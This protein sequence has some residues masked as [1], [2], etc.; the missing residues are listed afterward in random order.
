MAVGEGA[1]HHAEAE[2]GGRLMYVAIWLD[3]QPPTADERIVVCTPLL[4]RQ[5]AAVAILRSRRLAD[6]KSLILSAERSDLIAFL[7]ELDQ[8]DDSWNALTDDELVDAIVRKAATMA[9]SEVDFGELAAVAFYVTAVRKIPKPGSYP[10]FITKEAKPLWDDL[11]VRYRKSLDKF[12]SDKKMMWAAAVIMLKRLAAEKRV[13]PFTKDPTEDKVRKMARNEISRRANNGNFK[14]LKEVKEAFKF[15]KR[16]GLASALAPE[17]FLETVKHGDR[18]YVTTFQ[19]AA[20]PKGVKPSFAINQL[21]FGRRYGGKPE[22]FAHKN[23]DNLTDVLVEPKGKNLHF[24]LT[25]SLTRDQVILLFGLDEEVTD[26]AIRRT[27][28]R[29]GADWVRTGR[30]ADVA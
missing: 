8:A 29:A 17:A 6:A 27:L 9:V 15:L 20:L 1:S 26:A 24:H 22:K 2:K 23:I 5:G 19:Q 25:T 30:L 21:L 28:Q 12:K 3:P 7:K 11:T 13:K 16:A 14:A 4:P 10:R 18:Y